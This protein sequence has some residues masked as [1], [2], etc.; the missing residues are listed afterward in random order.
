[1]NVYSSYSNKERPIRPR[2]TSLD[3]LRFGRSVKRLRRRGK[4]KRKVRRPIAVEILCGVPLTTSARLF[5]LVCPAKA[6]EVEA[7]KKESSRSKRAT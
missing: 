7:K 5:H 1:M 4:L 2:P 3:L 6:A